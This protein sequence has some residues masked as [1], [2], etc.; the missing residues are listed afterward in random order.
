MDYKQNWSLSVGKGANMNTEDLGL[1]KYYYPIYKVRLSFAAGKWYVEYRR[2]P[3]YFF[4]KWWWFDDSVHTEYNDAQL[5]AN[6]LAADKG[7][8]EFRK[9]SLEIEILPEP[10][11]QTATEVVQEEAPE[12]KSSSPFSFMNRKSE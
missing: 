9:K 2:K 4:D 10:E 12:E 3:K 8:R 1:E 6:I 5:R 7:I 11:E